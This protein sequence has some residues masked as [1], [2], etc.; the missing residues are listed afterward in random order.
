MLLVAALDAD[1]ARHVAV[2]LGRW[3]LELE[4]DGMR[5]PAGARELE[6]QARAIGC[7]ASE[8]PAG[9]ISAA[10]DEL[11]HGQ[12]MAPLL[13]TYADAAQRLAVNVRTIKRQV[14]AGDLPVVHIG[15]AARIPHA[16]LEA[17][18]NGGAS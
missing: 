3:R 4:R 10:L 15:A 7:G 5:P 13:A 6:D 18:A 12:R 9:T 11:V 8:G 16:A 1:A 14:A 17:L 2:A